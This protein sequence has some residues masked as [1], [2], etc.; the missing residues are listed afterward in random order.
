MKKILVTGAAV[1][2]LSGCASIFN[3]TTQTVVL[4]SAPEGAVATVTNRAGMKVHDGATPVT[5]QLK[6]GAGYFKA[7]S[8]TVTFTK[9]GFVPKTVQLDASVSGW[10]IANILI[11]GA[12][13]MLVIDPATGAMY[14]FPS[15]LASTLDAQPGKTS[16]APGTLTIVSTD[17]LSAEQMKAARPLVPLQ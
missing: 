9:D 17:A 14:T 11:G 4:S 2:A 8:Y 1:L 12:L 6:R 3:G 10:Y 7:E 16:Q 13:G 5:L 15:T